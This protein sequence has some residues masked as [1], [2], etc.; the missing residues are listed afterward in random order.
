M[1][2]TVLVPAF[3]ADLS[4]PGIDSEAWAINYAVNR[5]WPARHKG[6]DIPQPRGTPILASSAGVVVGKSQNRRSRKGIEVIL[7]HRPEDTG[8]PFW[9]YSQYTHLQEMPPHPVGTAVSMGDEIG[10]PANTGKLGKRVRGAALKSA[11]LHPPRPGGP[12]LRRAAPP[13]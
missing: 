10:R 5:P 6:V 11:T 4:C 7:R 3:P 13:Q 9:T 12:P 2:R 1:V 8:L